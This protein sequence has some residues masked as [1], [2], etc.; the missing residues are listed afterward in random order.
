MGSVISSWVKPQRYS[1]GGGIVIVSAVSDTEVLK[2][3][4]FCD[5]F[6]ARAVRDEESTLRRRRSYFE[7]QGGFV[8]GINN[9]NSTFITLSF[10]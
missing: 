3:Q 9:N 7:K 5:L 4:L 2:S 10:I 6:V 1:G 8:S